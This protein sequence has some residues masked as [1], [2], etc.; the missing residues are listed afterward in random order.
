MIARRS[1]VLFAGLFVFQVFNRLAK[2]EKIDYVFAAARKQVF[3][4][5]APC[6][7]LNR[8]RVMLEYQM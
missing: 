3:K 5:R 8:V 1:L 7:V 4:Q 2:R 6:M